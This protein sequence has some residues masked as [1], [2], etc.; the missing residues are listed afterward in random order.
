ML[1]CY[2]SQSSPPYI[3]SYI[4]PRVRIIIK[5]K[6][7]I[8]E[9]SIGNSKATSISNTKKITTTIKNFI[10]KGKRGIL[11]GSNPHSNGEDFSLS[12]KVLKVTD[13]KIISTTV[14]KKH[15]DM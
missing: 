3:H 10:Q 7:S 9:K 15:V 11:L 4:A 6:T 12:T 5:E 8:P 13:I 2:T 1:N 14:I